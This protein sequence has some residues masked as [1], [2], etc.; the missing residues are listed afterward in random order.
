MC[1]VSDCYGAFF[2][3]QQSP[4]HRIARCVLR[5]YV[6]DMM[7]FPPKTICM[8]QICVGSLIYYSAGS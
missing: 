1:F 6:F 7:I 3:G 5:L 2:V 4:P 8:T